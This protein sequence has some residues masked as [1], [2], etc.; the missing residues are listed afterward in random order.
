MGFV[1]ANVK[2][3]KAMTVKYYNSANKLMYTIH[4]TNPNK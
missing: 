2:D 4:I 3:K 1:I